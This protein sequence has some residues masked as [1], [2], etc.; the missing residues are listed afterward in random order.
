MDT[1]DKYPEMK[2]Y[3]IIMDNAPIHVPEM[4]EVIIMQQGYTSV[5]LPSFLLRFGLLL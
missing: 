1:M 4:I 5:Y 2:G 3:F